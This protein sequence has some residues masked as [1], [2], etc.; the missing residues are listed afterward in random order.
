MEGEESKVYGK[1]DRNTQRGTEVVKSKRSSGACGRWR[2][3]C[4]SDPE[5]PRAARQTCSCPRSR[6]RGVL[7]EP[8][9]SAHVMSAIASTQCTEVTYFIV[10]ECILS[11]SQEQ[12][13]DL[14]AILEPIVL[15]ALAAAFL[16][17]YDG[18]DETR[19]HVE[20]GPVY[21]CR[22]VVVVVGISFVGSNEV[23]KVNL[24]GVRSV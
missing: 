3:P 5:K 16:A 19:H 24:S 23:G 4:G 14:M 2:H 20:L 6:C 1:R 21:L 10:H 8:V 13:P 18:V 7:C 11:V 15:S 22:V 17:L 9:A 12:L